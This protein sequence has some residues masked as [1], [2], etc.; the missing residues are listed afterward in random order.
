MQ[1]WFVLDESSGTPT[2]TGPFSREQIE[3]MV[4]AGSVRA[5]TRV[6]LAGS[7]DWVAASA[8]PGLAGLFRSTPP[9]APDFVQELS[10]AAV[11][12][13][14]T[15]GAAFELG[16]KSFTAKWSRWFV[17]A[18]VWF[19]IAMV[20]GIPQWITQFIGGATSESEDAGT[21]ALG[22][23]VMGVGGCF[24][25][26]LQLLV[27]APLFAGLVYAA[28]E[29]HDGR[30]QLQD[31]FQG[32]RRYGSALLG[33]L[34]LAGI[35]LA[36]AVVSAVPVMLAVA[37]AAVAQ[38]GRAAP[39]IAVF[40]GI[41][42]MTIVL[43]LLLALVLMRVLLA[44]V[45]AIDPRFGNPG[46]MEAFRISWRNTAGLG[47]SMLALLFVVGFVAALSV[48]LLCVGYVLV[49]IPL[50]ASVLGA[51]YVMTQRGRIG[52]PAAG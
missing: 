23:M 43:I 24:G 6:A 18:I 40:A 39:A 14:Y 10:Q 30:G 37:I 5:E 12:A 9:T 8:E 4:A 28:A 38:G 15:F 45:I 42:V 26:V 33:A 20:I 48:L 27:G 22:A 25:L 52:A 47:F 11:C 31:L 1:S 17:L 51:M 49:G 41:A 2:P 35:Y 29:I 16:W 32:F 7:Q 46:V 36:C 44:P 50:L 13:P 3:A 34:L 21:R 19:A